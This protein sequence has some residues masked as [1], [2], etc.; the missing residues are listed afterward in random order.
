M[1]LARIVCKGL[2]AKATY[3]PSHHFCFP[4]SKGARLSQGVSTTRPWS[5]EGIAPLIDRLFTYE[6]HSQFTLLFK[7][8][9]LR[10][11]SDLFSY[12]QVVVGANDVRLQ[13]TQK[14]NCTQVAERITLSSTISSRL[15]R[16]GAQLAV[17]LSFI[18]LIS[19]VEKKYSN[20]I[21]I[22]LQKNLREKFTQEF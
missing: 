22:T 3:S 11:L 16:V 13:T 6:F 2:L 17:L 10:T 8:A 12:L 7:Y 15:W 9:I 1:S 20:L 19:K 21:V 4:Y 18:L 5:S 14:K